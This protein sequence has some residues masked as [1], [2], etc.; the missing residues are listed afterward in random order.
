MGQHV[1]SSLAYLRGGVGDGQVYSWAWE[2]PPPSIG[3][4]AAAQ[5]VLYDLEWSSTAAPSHVAAPT[6]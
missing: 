6:S 1:L 5:M 4:L 2:V 3:P